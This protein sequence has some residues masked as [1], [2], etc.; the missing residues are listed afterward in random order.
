LD[1]QFFFKKFKYIYCL[2][3]K[4]LLLQKKY[5]EALEAVEKVLVYDNKNIKGLLRKAMICKVATLLL[6]L[7]L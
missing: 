6:L 4:V 3:F 1:Q 2:F 7:L 5:E